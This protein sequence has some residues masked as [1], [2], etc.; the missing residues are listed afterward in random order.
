MAVS[1]HTIEVQPQGRIWQRWRR[2]G[3]GCPPYGNA[4]VDLLRWTV[5]DTGLAVLSDPVQRAALC[6][7][8]SLNGDSFAIPDWEPVTEAWIPD[9]A[10]P[11]AMYIFRAGRDSWLHAGA[12]LVDPAAINNKAKLRSSLKRLPVASP[13]AGVR[14][15]VMCLCAD[16]VSGRASLSEVRRDDAFGKWQLP[17]F[18]ASYPP[19]RIDGPPALTHLGEPF[20]VVSGGGAA[21]MKSGLFVLYVDLLGRERGWLCFDRL[22]YR[23]EGYF[24]SQERSAWFGEPTQVS[25]FLFHKPPY[26]TEMRRAISPRYRAPRDPA[27]R[28]AGRSIG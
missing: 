23:F 7:T 9:T 18:R 28:G 27:N 6:G 1:V 22:G 13:E 17:S 11:G 12:A 26:L 8:L 10:A 3:R 14:M 4:E 20:D 25:P 24:A 16:P 19:A 2:D 15:A 5:D 21:V